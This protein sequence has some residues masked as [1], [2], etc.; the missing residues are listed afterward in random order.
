MA[1][2]PSLRIVKSFTYRGATQEW[3][4]TYHFNGGTPA[5]T[6]AWTTFADNVVNAE[7]LATPPYVTIVRAIGYTAGSTVAAFTKS[8]TTVGTLSTTGDI[9]TPG[10]A[11]ALLRF[12]TPAFTSKGHPVYL[13]NYYHGPTANTSTPDNVGA[14]MVTA[15]N[16]YGTAWLAGFSDGTNTLVRAGPNGV[17][18]SARLTKSLVTHRDFPR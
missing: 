6:T 13:F 5:N 2:T 1:A 12:S 14:S 15:L 17:T 7:K 10:D 9:R 8:Y 4:N 16:T 3:S 11:A 18:A